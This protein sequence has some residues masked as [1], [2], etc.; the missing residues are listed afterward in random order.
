[1]ALRARYGIVASYAGP[2]ERARFAD[3]L[4]R[5]GGFPAEVV[6]F[7]LLGPDT[8]PITTG[9]NRNALLLQGAGN[10]SL[11]VDDDTICSVAPVPEARDGL[12]LSSFID[13]TEFW[14]FREG[15]PASPPGGFQDADFLNLHEQL[16]GRDVGA[17]VE[18]T[19]ADSTPLD[20]DTASLSFFRQLR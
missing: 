15:E 11:Q 8:H 7:A 17:C 13:P 9:A 10:L 14:F 20:L 12:R 5:H 19:M 4:C 1:E 2:E 6:R 16:L 18:R 3:S